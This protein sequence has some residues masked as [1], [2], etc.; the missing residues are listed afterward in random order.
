MVPE[1]AGFGGAAGG[2]VLGIEVQHQFAPFKFRQGAD[3]AVLVLGLEGRG[4]ITDGGSAHGSKIN[5]LRFGRV[6]DGPNSVFDF[7][8]EAMNS[9]V[10]YLVRN[11]QF[12]ALF[13]QGHAFVKA[14]FKQMVFGIVGREYPCIACTESIICDA[15]HPILDAEVQGLTPLAA[16]FFGL[17]QAADGWGYGIENQIQTTKHFGLRMVVVTFPTS[18]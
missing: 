6:V 10:A 13:S 12:H 5:G 4:L 14:N 11:K 8:G 7:Q 16:Y 2:I 3:L 9:A 1:I 17:K 15:G 18:G